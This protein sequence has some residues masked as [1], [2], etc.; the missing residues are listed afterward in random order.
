MTLQCQKATSE[1]T[2]DMLK[3]IGEYAISVQS[4]AE[5]LEH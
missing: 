3:D 1:E 5:I 2:K 4:P